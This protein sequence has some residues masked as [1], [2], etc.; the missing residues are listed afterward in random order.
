M[1]AE[2]GRVAAQ[3]SHAAPAQPRQRGLEGQDLGGRI[4]LTPLCDF[5]PMHLHPDGMARRIRWEGNDCG[6]P[7]WAKVLD[8]VCELGAQVQQEQQKKGPA[9]VLCAPRVQVL[10]AMAP[11][12]ERLAT[13]GEALGLEPEVLNHLRP[14]VL[15]LPCDPKRTHAMETAGDHKAGSVRLQQ[16]NLGCIDHSTRQIAEQ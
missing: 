5:A 2:W 8:R 6:Q 11:E 15:R 14:G 13:E 16:P 10:K 1:K 9:P 12:L 3:G 4:A 7:D